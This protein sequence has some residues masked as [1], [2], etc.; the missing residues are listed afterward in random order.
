LAWAAAVAVA[1]ATL[2]LVPRWVCGG[3]AAEWYRGSPERARTL[4]TAV[5]RDVAGLGATSFTTGSRR[6][7]AEWR[8]GSAVM[9]AL[10][11][12]QTALEHAELR[13]WALSEMD[14][15][16]DRALACRDFDTEAWGEDALRA[17]DG[18]RGHAALL[19]YLN[20]AL[21]VRRFVQPNSRFSPTNDHFTEALARRFEA[22]PIGLVETYP[23]ERYP[24]DNTSGIASIALH[25]RALGAP[26][27]PLVARW[28]ARLEADSVDSASG[29]L[30]QAVDARGHAADRGRASGTA[31]AAY[32][33]SFADVR[34]SRALFRALRQN[35][36]GTVLGFGVVSEY[37]SHGDAGHGDI[38]SGPLVFGWSISAMG[39][40]ISGCR[41]HRD[42]ACF[43]ELYRAIDLFGAPYRRADELRFV[44]G[45][46]L[47]NAI[48][49]AMLTALPSERWR[50]E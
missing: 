36:A 40:S 33:L 11:F 45:G 48:L 47:G 26:P 50:A 43:T 30:F 17:L 41:I 8:F 27:R 19:G 23:G 18:E 37:A 12:G 13:A 39:F 46:P 38:D 4:G 35:A 5:G 9:A 24:V 34:A 29:L 16:L 1:L 32:F 28:L 20:L 25:D 10:G 42:A 31:L 49:F 14:R 3:G 22:S 6:F 44:S 15:A 21:S 2:E 7:D